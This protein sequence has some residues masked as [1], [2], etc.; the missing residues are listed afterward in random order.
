MLHNF[1][2]ELNKINNIKKKK[3]LLSLIENNM[4]FECCLICELFKQSTADNIEKNI[5]IDIIKICRTSQDKDKIIQMIQE[6]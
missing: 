2:L 3:M 4:F 5:Y 1:Q 6:W